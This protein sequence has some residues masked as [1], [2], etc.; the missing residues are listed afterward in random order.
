MSVSATVQSSGT[1]FFML[2]C[3]MFPWHPG[4]DG[5]IDPALRVGMPHTFIVPACR[6][7]IKTSRFEEGVVFGHVIAHKLGHLLLGPNAMPGS[8]MTQIWAS[9]SLATRTGAHCSQPGRSPA[10]ARALGR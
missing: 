3:S 2:I 10:D 8:I 4:A 1:P 6:S 9:E 5:L 7:W